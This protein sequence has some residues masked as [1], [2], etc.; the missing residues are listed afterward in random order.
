MTK[1]PGSNP[2]RGNAISRVFGAL[3]YTTEVLPSSSTL[4]ESLSRRIL[5]NR[6]RRD[7]VV[8]VL[9]QWLKEGRGVKQP[10]LQD[11]INRLRKSNQYSHALQ[12][13][14]WMSDEMKLDLSPADVFA[15][16]DLISK[17]RGLEEAEKYF[18]GIPDQLKGLQAYFGLLHCYAHHKSLEQAETTFQ[19]MKELGFAKGV[20]CYNTMLTLYSQMGKYRKLDILV[21]EMEEK[22]IGYNLRT[23]NILLNSY[24]AT[25]DIDRMEKLL[26]KM[27]ADPL[28]T[29]DWLNYNS[30]ANAFLRVGL[31]EK[32][33]ALLRRSEQ[34]ITL[35]TR[36][37][38][39]E[40][41]LASY[42][43]LGNKDEVYRIWNL[44]KCM[45][46]FYNSGYRSMSISLVK[47][48]DIDGAEKIV[49]E[50]ESR[51]KT[52]DILIPNVLVNAYCKKGLLEKASSYSKK[53]AESGR[54]DVSTWAVLATGY[55]MN[56]QMEEAVEA[57]QK[58][59]NL[60]NG[61]G[62]QFNRL[63]VASC[64]LY[65]KK[66]GDVELAHE[67]LRLLR[68]R[69]HLTTAVCNELEDSMDGEPKVLETLS[70][71]KGNTWWG[72]IQFGKEKWMGKWSSS[73]TRASM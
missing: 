8:P 27:E 20:G 40:Y 63:T 13:S 73:T 50:W 14:E 44:Y 34:L 66:T 52:F 60:E 23:L 55:S 42:A 25:S 6:T 31:R 32:A 15:R 46:R 3:F 28:V 64:L 72:L 30:A 10:D 71:E 9:E 35:K 38:A 12:I 67:L 2:W 19:K 69:G 4:S 39:Y 33:Q 45:G 1:L 41:L 26:L 54:E 43:S 68:E 70:G 57:L 37:V 53:L 61:S 49:E 7:S 59:A 18:D 16:L 24:A 62:W 36:K 5:Q 29:M 17:V 51:F 65:L 22:G 47:M 48:D 21:K 56:G 58:A 11:S